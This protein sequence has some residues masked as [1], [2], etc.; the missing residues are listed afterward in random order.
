MTKDDIKKSIIIGVVSGFTAAL[1]LVFAVWAHTVIIHRYRDYSERIGIERGASSH[2]DRPD[3][4]ELIEKID[5]M[6]NVKGRTN[7]VR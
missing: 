4:K 5:S 7:S 3:M 1:T 6:K 2:C